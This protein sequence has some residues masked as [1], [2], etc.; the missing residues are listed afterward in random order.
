MEESLNPTNSLKSLECA[1]Q[2][3]I[4][5]YEWILHN[6]LVITLTALTATQTHVK[7]LVMKTYTIKSYFE[8]ACMYEKTTA[9]SL[10]LLRLVIEVAVLTA[11]D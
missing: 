8:A 2:E 7:S 5:S 3:Q 4:C 1:T 10:I 11:L 9:P 6:I